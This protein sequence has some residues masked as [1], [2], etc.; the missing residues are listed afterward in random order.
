MQQR[1]RRPRRRRSSPS[2]QSPHCHHSSLADKASD[3]E[4]IWGTSP[5]G[6]HDEDDVVVVS[7]GGV[8]AQA[9]APKPL[10][11]ALLANQEDTALS[12]RTAESYRSTSSSDRNSSSNRSSTSSLDKATSVSST[13]SHRGNSSKAAGSSRSVSTSPEP[14]MLRLI[15]TC[16]SNREQEKADVEEDV[17][18]EPP[19]LFQQP[20]LS[21]V[22]GSVTVVQIGDSTCSPTAMQS[23]MDDN[24]D[25]DVTNEDECNADSIDKIVEPTILNNGAPPPVEHNVENNKENLPSTDTTAMTA[26]LDEEFTAPTVRRRT[27]CSSAE[28]SKNNSRRTSPLYSEPADALPPQLAAQ[29]WIKNQQNRPLPMPP[30]SS[31]SSEFTTFTKDGYVRC[32]LPTLTQSTPQNSQSNAKTS[33]AVL[34]SSTPSSSQSAVSKQRPA[35]APFSGVTN[36]KSKQVVMPKPPR[37]L[38]PSGPPSVETQQNNNKVFPS[39]IYLPTVNE[40]NS[41]TIQV[42]G[43]IDI[44]YTWN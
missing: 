6:S 9:L 23:V 12:D 25:V 10:L 35:T 18:I 43:S 16:E 19:L 39:L 24:L 22:T 37:Q 41:L 30:F 17:H 20:R 15:P 27:S 4:D 31:A 5:G 44:I 11:A 33:S 29:Y 38:P 3:Y 26:S 13:R 36:N 40:D 2:G 34:S 21:T 42:F 32:T 7:G 8:S 14:P 28:S 1:R